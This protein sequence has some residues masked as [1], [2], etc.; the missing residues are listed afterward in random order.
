[1]MNFVRVARSIRVSTATIAEPNTYAQFARG[2]WAS[3]VPSI[4]MKSAQSVQPD[5]PRQSWPVAS[6][7]QRS[8]FGPAPLQ[9]LQLRAMIRTRF[10]R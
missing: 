10:E 5:R 7:E 8:P 6:V 4:E 9:S 2:L 1:M 3:A